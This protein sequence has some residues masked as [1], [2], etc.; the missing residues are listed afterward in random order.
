MY[1]ILAIYELWSLWDFCDNWSNS[2]QKTTQ[3]AARRKHAVCGGGFLHVV[4]G[5]FEADDPAILN[6]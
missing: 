6:I 2:G 5:V 4:S 3:V 1:N